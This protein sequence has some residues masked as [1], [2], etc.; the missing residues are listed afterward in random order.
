MVS[1]SSGL[2]HI[3]LNIL[4]GASLLLHFIVSF[5]IYLYHC[6]AGFNTIVMTSL[7]TATE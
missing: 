2:N 7:S 3:F 6:M 5:R 1:S 4:F